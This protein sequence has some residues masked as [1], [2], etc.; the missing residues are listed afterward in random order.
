MNKEISGD[1]ICLDCG[2][3]VGDRHYTMLNKEGPYCLQC[4]D[5]A[6]ECEEEENGQF[7]VGA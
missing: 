1:F 4:I 6:N 2:V 3:N 7:G 5:I